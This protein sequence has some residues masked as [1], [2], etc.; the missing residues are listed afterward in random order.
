MN[1][2]PPVIITY[3]QKY[4]K[5]ETTCNCILPLHFATTWLHPWEGG[6]GGVS[7]LLF[8]VFCVMLCFGVLFVFVLCLDCLMLPLSLD[9]P[10][11]IALLFSPTFIYKL[12]SKF[13]LLLLTV[14][15]YGNLI[16]HYID[17]YYVLTVADILWH[18]VNFE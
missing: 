1:R 16:R 11:L 4:Q 5:T 7:V 13:Y 14:C 6:F 2:Q 15:I 9:C 8:L 10:F 17:A 3:K 18:T 12:H